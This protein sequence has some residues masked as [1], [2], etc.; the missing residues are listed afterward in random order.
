M[1]DDKIRDRDRP[2]ATGRDVDPSTATAGGAL[3]HSH[4]LDHFDIPDGRPDPRGWDVRSG[5]G[6]KLGKV[7]DLIV[8]SET[9]QIRYLE[10][11][12]DDDVRKAGGRDFTLVPI[13]AARLDDDRDDV[14]VNLSATDLRDVP[15]FELDRSTRDDER[16]LHGYVAERATT[17]RT[18]DQSTSDLYASPYYDDRSFFGSRRAAT[19][20]ESAVRRGENA[21]ERGAHR[22]ANAIDDVKDRI[23]GNPASRPG[24]DPT[25]RRF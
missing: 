18:V 12:V 21:V 23:D 1:A 6:T 3:V 13:G 8:D 7:E 11:A 9:R 17:R 20:G 4:D 25:D 16:K 19:S 5:D 14:I 24:P 22:A 10:I 2:L 15:V